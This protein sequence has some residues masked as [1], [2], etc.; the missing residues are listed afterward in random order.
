MS[1]WV[2]IVGEDNFTQRF[3][4]FDN[5]TNAEFDGTAF[6]NA[7][8]FIQSTDFATDFPT[9]GTSMTIITLNPM[10]VELTILKSFMPQVEG[11][12]YG[13]IQ[14]VDVS[15]SPDQN[16]KTFG[17]DIRVIRSLSS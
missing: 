7:T 9:G 14:I 1:D 11:Q 12:Y 15:P 13:Q 4:L 8:M 6:D 5:S 2:Y 17:I 16:R 3:L 10:V